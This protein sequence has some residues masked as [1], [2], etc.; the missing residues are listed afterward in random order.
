MT[1]GQ[2]VELLLPGTRKIQRWLKAVFILL[3]P[4]LAL[5]LQ[6]VLDMGWP[7]TVVVWGVVGV[8]AFVLAVD[9]LA[10]RSKLAKPEALVLRIG[11][12]NHIVGREDDIDRLARC[13]RDALQ[14]HLV[15]ESG[16]GKSA[17]VQ[18][19]LCPA[20]DVEGMLLPIYINA[21]GEDWV[22]GPRSELLIKLWHALGD[23][24]RET[25]GLAECPKSDQ[26]VQLLSNIKEK[27]GRTALLVFDQFDDYQTRHRDLFL[28]GRRKTWLSAKEL[29]EDNPF[30][31]DIGR[32]LKSKAL[33]C[34]FVTRAD[35]SD[36]LE[37]I[38][39]CEPQTYHLDRVHASVVQPLLAQLT[40]STSDDAPTVI[41]PEFGWERLAERLARDMARDGPVLPV[42]MKIVF[43]ALANLPALTVRDYES[44]GSLQGL[45]AGF[46]EQRVATAARHADSSKDW[47]LQV[48]LALVDRDTEKTAPKSGRELGKQFPAKPNNGR[49]R[50]TTKLEVLLEY[51]QEV[52]LV[53]SS[54]PSGSREIVFMLDHE[55]LC[56]AILEADR[57]R[58]RCFVEVE[59]ARRSFQGAGLNLWLRWQSMLRPSLQ[60]WL[61][62]RWLRGR[63]RYGEARRFALWSL[64]RF[65][66]WILMGVLFVGGLRQYGTYQDERAIARIVAAGG[67]LGD[68]RGKQINFAPQTANDATLS[69][70]A[71][72]FRRFETTTLNLSETRIGD[73]STLTEL[74][75]LRALYID[76][77]SVS[78]LAPLSELPNLEVLEARRSEIESVAFEGK[79][80]CLK[81]L[82][83]VGNSQ[84]DILKLV[85][86]K[87]LTEVAASSCALTQIDLRELDRLAHLD[88]SANSLEDE[89]VSC[90]AKLTNL[91]FLDLSHNEVTRFAIRDFD[92]LTDLYLSE[93]PGLAEV[94]LRNLP[95]LGVL[96]LSVNATARE[97]IGTT[98]DLRLD[99]LPSLA[100]VYLN[101]QGIESLSPLRD[102][103][104]M[105]RLEL[106]NT[107]VA[108]LSP[109]TEMESLETLFLEQTPVREF[110]P[111]FE[112]PALRTV[113]VSNDMMTEDEESELENAYEEK[114]SR[115][116]KV[117]RVP[118]EF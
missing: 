73:I 71:S 107:L 49:R 85:G 54:V 14:V 42:R 18:T 58:E 28:P 34:L 45:E 118:P 80:P 44:C 84:L 4:S 6:S 41:A 105:T 63:F 72:D 51:L 60:L 5:L 108:D 116:L 15:G 16:T 32:L 1:A 69:F 59:E 20:L 79:P 2:N 104:S 26:F 86:I 103:R 111:L 50:G 93:N 52:E 30:W 12:P 91:V 115:K 56:H 70:L 8:L 47:A 114:W 92:V 27:L 25:L 77:T 117:T 57:R 89:A 74:P 29:V 17:L 24:D 100:E 97:E 7:A 13:C 68:S 38:R 66:V 11:D 3:G 53:R 106:N 112:L 37:S 81:I 22:E 98:L 95:K 110:A 9:I 113:Y 23:S 75:N 62:W 67:S 102:L 78:S 36:G 33:R 43:Q 99:D 10:Q 94:R 55:Y 96:R 82:Y 40:A 21:W 46:I 39:F 109:I 48:L 64:I 76:R 65:N 87:A 88:L 83:L 35:A 101:G 61:A 19:L 31:A 90:I